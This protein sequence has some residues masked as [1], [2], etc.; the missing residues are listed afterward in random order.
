[1]LNAEHGGWTRAQSDAAR[2]LM[3]G[4]YRARIDLSTLRH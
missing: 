2:K 4:F 1:V 3:A